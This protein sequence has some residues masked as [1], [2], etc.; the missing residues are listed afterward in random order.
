VS[1]APRRLELCR[2]AILERNFPALAAIVEQDSDRMHAVMMTSSPALHYLTPASLAVMAAV[3]AWRAAGVPVC[4]TV[5]AG[6]NVHVLC[7][8][9]EAAQVAGRV[10]ELEGVGEV[11]T[12]GV[13]GPAELVHE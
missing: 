9:G 4:Y 6:P 13:G 10:R 12:S 7:P 1:D 5:D 8:A 3:Q 11:L 2:A